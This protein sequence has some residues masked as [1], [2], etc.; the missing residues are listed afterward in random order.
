MIVTAQLQFLML[1]TVTHAVTFLGHSVL[2]RVIQALHLFRL[3][4]VVEDS[5]GCPRSFTVNSF[6]SHNAIDRYHD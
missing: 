4:D 5:G 2:A 1:H 3:L 6:G